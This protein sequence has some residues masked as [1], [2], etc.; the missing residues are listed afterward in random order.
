MRA[1]ESLASANENLAE[2][3][4][5]WRLDSARRLASKK[6][7]SSSGSASNPSVLTA[8]DASILNMLVDEE[9]NM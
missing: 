2:E 7:S 5:Q 9:K 8:E 3:I 4:H 6:T 1:H